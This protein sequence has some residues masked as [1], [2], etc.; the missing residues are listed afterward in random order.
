MKNRRMKL[1]FSKEELKKRS[2]TV[3]FHHSGA[4]LGNMTVDNKEFI[5]GLFPEHKSDK[6]QNFQSALRPS[7]DVPANVEIKPEEFLLAP[8]RLLSA[9]IVGAGTWKATDFSD[10][11]VLR[12][13]L[14]LLAKKP[15]YRN[16]WMDPD[17]WAGI[18]QELSWTPAFM[19]NGKRIPSGIDGLLAIDTVGEDNAQLARG[20]LTGAVRSNS[21]TIEFDWVPSHEF[22]D[23]WTFERQIGTMVDGRMVTRVV[24]NII[25][26]HETSIVGLGADPY[27]KSIDA[28]GELTDIDLGGSQWQEISNSDDSD[29]K[30]ASFQKEVRRQRYSVTG[31][32]EGKVF[33]FIKSPKSYIE[34]VNKAK[35]SAES[36]ESAIQLGANFG[37][38]LNELLGARLEARTN[39]NRSELIQQMADA[40][41]MTVRNVQR[42]LSGEVKCAS[43]NIIQKWSPIL[44]TQAIVLIDAAQ[45]DGCTY[46]NDEIESVF[47]KED[48]NSIIIAVAEKE[49]ALEVAKVA[50]AEKVKQLEIEKAKKLEDAAVEL[51]A[52]KKDTAKESGNLDEFE[53]YKVSSE[54]TMKALRALNIQLKEENDSS[55]SAFKTKAAEYVAQLDLLKKNN[56]D[57]LTS[58]TDLVKT[59]AV[60]KVELEN[61]EETRVELS[62]L[63]KHTEELSSKLAEFENKSHLI[64]IGEDHFNSMKKEAV[65]L[66]SAAMGTNASDAVIGLFSRAK[67]LDEIN[68]LVEQYSKKLASELGFRCTSCGSGDY[69]F[70]SVISAIDADMVVEVDHGE[71]PTDDDIRKEF[72]NFKRD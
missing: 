10:E 2:A 71:V 4:G 68:G 7:T 19:Q 1:S 41:V 39:E 16:H 15:V 5:K 33:T 6:L 43:L 27:A 18:I 26:Y 21:V 38:K 69:E 3:D 70:A 45:Q 56:S 52:N 72:Q 61:Y 24:T 50:K 13:S 47:G 37:I 14:P 62:D 20:I 66:Y 53:A 54:K 8:F 40:G 22:E 64:E 49:E 35:E 63:K 48:F 59:N 51:E 30:L 9:T 42:Y 17:S 65:R 23:D 67:T 34:M 12:R 55:K 29:E 46:E 44:F 57:L 60:Q 28:N 58:N 32:E 31:E 25:D 36:K 11:R